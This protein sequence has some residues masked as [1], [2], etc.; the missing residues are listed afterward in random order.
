VILMKRLI[1]VIVA[2]L[3]VPAAFAQTPPAS[4][5]KSATV[6]L[7]PT[8]M[9]LR[10]VVRSLTDQTGARI[11][12]G[13]EV[14]GKPAVR[15]DG[16][17]L[18]TALTVITNST[19][20]K[21]SRLDVRS[22]DADALTA[23]RAVALAAAADLLAAGVTSARTS[24]GAEVAI[25]TAPPP[26]KDT[27]A[28]YLIQTRAD[29][30]AIRAAREAA[31]KAARDADKAA[32]SSLSPDAKDDPAVVD[33]YSTLQRLNPNQLAVVAREFMMRMTPDEQKALGEAMAQ[34]RGKMEEMQRP[35]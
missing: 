18:E 11:L 13:P 22:K 9:D 26:S 8:Q 29:V 32:N 28:V 10:A 24:D 25:V 27:T 30:A 23:D 35:Q 2:A 7:S 15:L 3:T 4:K 33:A 19:D 20:N 31:E 12:I 1:P 14:T 34:Q 5:P 6:T 21:W 16:V 17:P